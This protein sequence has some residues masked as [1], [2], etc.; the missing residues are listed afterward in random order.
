MNDQ[1]KKLRELVDTNKK[2]QKVIAVSSGKG[3]VGKTSI[4]AN[5]AVALSNINKKVILF[6]GDL[7]LANVDIVLGIKTSY[8][9]IDVINKSKKLEEIIVDYNQNLKIIP[10]GS[11][12]EEISNVA[13]NDLGEILDKL[14]ELSAQSDVLLIDTGAGI[15]KKV[16]T[17]LKNALDIVIV[18]TPEPTSIAD[19]YATI[20]IL[21]LNYKRKDIKMFINM[22]KDKQEAQNVFNN[23]N[24][25][26]EKF[27]NTKLDMA[28]YSL[29][30][31]NLSSSIKS[32]KPIIQYNPDSSFSIS[33][34]RLINYFF[35][36][37]IKLIDN[38]IKMFFNNLFG[39]I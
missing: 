2:N 26:C 12:I 14:N 23:M 36:Q 3:G 29:F 7:G 31:K 10:A 35:S 6:D 1:A 37:N 22:V 32:Q 13:E 15:S 16:M 20:K 30:D 34:K 25:I 18:A 39:R 11:G 27:L 33:I 24:N 17:L 8:S 38:P 19:A 5:M 4:V 21:T 9:I 28:S